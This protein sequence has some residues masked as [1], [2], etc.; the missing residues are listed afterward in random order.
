MI[1]TLG[2]ISVISAGLTAFVLW[3]FL[4]VKKQGNDQVKKYLAW[5][6]L[7]SVLSIA[8]TLYYLI[9]TNQFQYH[10]VWH[11]SALDLPLHFK[12]SCLW[13]GQEGSFLLWV[14]WNALLLLLLVA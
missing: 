1:G 13:E 11:H 8:G 14:F 9:F 3:V 12:I 7:A 10:Y 2:H 4:L 6:H 5:F